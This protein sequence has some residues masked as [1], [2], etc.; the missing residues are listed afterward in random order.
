MEETK[1]TNPFKTDRAQT[2]AIDTTT[3]PQTDT[4]EMILMALWD[5]LEKR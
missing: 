4:I 2:K 3:T 1:P 5:F